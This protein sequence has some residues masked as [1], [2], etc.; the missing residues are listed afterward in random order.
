MKPLLTVLAA[1]ALLI[2]EGLL[3]SVERLAEVLG[4]RVLL[5]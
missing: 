1:T 2:D 5:L 4:L 3:V